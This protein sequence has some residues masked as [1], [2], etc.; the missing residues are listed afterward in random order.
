MPLSISELITQWDENGD[1]FT[2]PRPGVHYVYDCRA[3]SSEKMYL[4]DMLHDDVMN[5]HHTTTQRYNLRPARVVVD[6][7]LS[8]EDLLK[9]IR[10]EM[11]H[12][13]GC[14]GVRKTRKTRAQSPTESEVSAVSSVSDF[15]VSDETHSIK[16]VFEGRYRRGDREIFISFKGRPST[17]EIL[18]GATIHRPD[19]VTVA[20][21]EDQVQAHFDTS[22]GRLTKCPVH[23]QL[24]SESRSYKKQLKRR[25]PHREDLV[26]LIVDNIFDRRGGNVQIRGESIPGRRSVGPVSYGEVYEHEVKPTVPLS[27][28]ATR[29]SNPD[30]SFAADNISY[31]HE[32]GELNYVF[33]NGE[34]YGVPHSYEE[35]IVNGYLDD[36]QGW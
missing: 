12:G 7:D 27:E 6:P 17:G 24:P 35:A 26:T 28:D 22:R 16:T 3:A 36:G 31:D 25:A 21:T 9:T 29:C 20:L 4:R 1:E 8:Y 34:C 23:Y 11:C 30:G 14:K 2:I 13:A 5:H 10:W 19:S 32:K 15:R 33:E 18:Y